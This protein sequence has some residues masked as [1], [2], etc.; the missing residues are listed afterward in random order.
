MLD[1]H[2][3]CLTKISFAGPKYV[4]PDLREAMFFKKTKFL[5]FKHIAGPKQSNVVKIN[6]ALMS[7]I[8]YVKIYDVTCVT[9]KRIEASSG[10]SKA[11]LLK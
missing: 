3:I 4:L 1:L 8:L 11:R 7:Q 2:T 6:G 9:L 10:Q 5:N